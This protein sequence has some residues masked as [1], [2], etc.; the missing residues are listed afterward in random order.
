M[1]WRS[2]EI[3]PLFYKNPYIF[4]RAAYNSTFTYNLYFWLSPLGPLAC[5]WEL[6]HHC[7][8]CPS[9]Q[10]P[11]VPFQYKTYK[12]F[13]C[14]HGCLARYNVFVWVP[15]S[16]FGPDVLLGHGHGDTRE[17]EDIS[18]YYP[19]HTFCCRVWEKLH[20]LLT[21]VLLG[22]VMVLVQYC[23]CAKCWSGEN[24]CS[25]RCCNLFISKD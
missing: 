18:W 17:L 10:F 25:E 6:V 9:M 24:S 22:R 14:H 19:E 7:F 11:F 15:V 4:I 2:R 1:Q 21:N 13:L 23:G 3:L 8:V 12:T 16:Y 5:N 20:C